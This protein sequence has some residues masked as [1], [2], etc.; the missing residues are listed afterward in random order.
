M[1]VCL[2]LPDGAVFSVQMNEPALVTSCR[3]GLVDRSL[4]WRIA[5]TFDADALIKVSLSMGMLLHMWSLPDV[6][7]WTDGRRIWCLM[8]CMYTP[9][10]LER[11]AF[12]KP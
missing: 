1:Q 11:I 4:S 3:S 9:M 5:H 12:Q 2:S 6:F 7:H 10:L 8:L